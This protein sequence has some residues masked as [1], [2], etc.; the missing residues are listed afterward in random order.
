M[1]LNKPSSVTKKIIAATVLATIIVGVA[2]W[3]F[4]AFK[5]NEEDVLDETEV[6]DL[7]TTFVE[8]FNNK[9]FD[10]FCN[11][12]TPND[13]VLLRQAVDKLGGKEHFFDNNFAKTFTGNNQSQDFGES[14]TLS[15]GELTTKK[16]EIIDGKFNGKDMNALNITSVYT[17][18]GML[19]TTGS[20]QYKV[21]ESVTFVCIKIDAEW[22][23]YTMTA[24]PFSTK[25]DA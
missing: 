24:T 7:V 21:V 20:N 4:Y 17:V 14:V 11:C 15:L 6:K 23:I 25:T 5:N 16:E 10:A 12:Y 18:K 13:Q 9:D 3:V 1:E 8:S 2:F 22:Y 19:T